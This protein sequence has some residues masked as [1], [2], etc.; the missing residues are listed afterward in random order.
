[1]D[2]PA[3]GR[4]EERIVTTCQVCPHRW[5]DHDALGRRFCSATLEV[6]WERGCICR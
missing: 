1:M 5:A 4:H 2:E 6:G 3:T